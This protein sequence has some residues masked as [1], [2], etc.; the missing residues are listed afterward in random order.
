M[1]GIDNSQMHTLLVWYVIHTKQ[2]NIARFERVLCDAFKHDFVERGVNHCRNPL[3]HPQWIV[4]PSFL[5]RHK[6][7]FSTVVQQAGDILVIL[8]R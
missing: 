1:T 7:K 8:P 4:T 6:I 2:G 5:R 3:Q